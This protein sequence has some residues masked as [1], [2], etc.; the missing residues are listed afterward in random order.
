[1]DHTRGPRAR[2]HGAATRQASFP[3]TN[4]RGTGHTLAGRADVLVLGAG[5]VGL[6]S[7]LAIARRGVTVMMLSRRLPGE[8][9]P[10]AAGLIAPGIA[11]L[12]PQAQ[13]FARAARDGYP[14]FLEELRD[15]GGPA[16]PYAFDG[17]L[18]IP[19]DAEGVERRQAAPAAGERWLDRAE[20]ARVEPAVTNVAGA[21]LH[22]RDG[23]V[24]NAAL[25]RALEQRARATKR[26]TIVD[27][28]ADELSLDGPHPVVTTAGGERYAGDRVVIATGAWTAWLRGLPSAIPVEPVRGQMLALAGRRLRLPIVAEHVYLTPRPTETHVGSTL[29]RVGLQVGTSPDVLDAFR[30]DASALVPALSDAPVLRA[31]SGLRPMT[32]DLLP[33]IGHHPADPRL[34]LACGHS[35][36]GILLA[37]LTGECVAGLVS[38]VEPAWDLSPFNLRRFA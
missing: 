19:H 7:A 32:S 21:V 31:W 3:V 30:R 16:V 18:E 26:L 36:N 22:E 35:R 38:G 37:P 1:M 5:L 15:A 34:V 28:L 12:G 4:R 23:W 17:V 9:S 25:L 20:L 11:P 33:I 29:E 13:S 6:A 10:A 14:A 27:A 2:F 8:A 24:D